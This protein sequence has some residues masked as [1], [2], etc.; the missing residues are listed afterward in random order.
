MLERS[1]T[2]HC[3]FVAHNGADVYH[4]IEADAG[5]VIHTGQPTLDEYSTK[6]A[7]LAAI[8]EEHRPEEVV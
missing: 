3:W 6:E 4:L 7:A 1:C 5:Q 8:P 2:K